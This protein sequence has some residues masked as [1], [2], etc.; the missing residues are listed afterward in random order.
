MAI[1]TLQ[2]DFINFAKGM[3]AVGISWAQVKRDIDFLASILAGTNPGKPAASMGDIPMP[4]HNLAYSAFIERLTIAPKG[5]GA[6]VDIKIAAN[7]H[8]RGAPA[9]V[10]YAYEIET[11]TPAPVVLDFDQSTNE[12]FWRAEGI[13]TPQING[14]FGTNAD[15][16]LATTDFPEPKRDSYLNEVDRIIKWITA[17]TFVRLVIQAL[18]RYPLGELAPWLKFQA[19]VLT[20]YTASH[21][22][23]TASKATITVGGCESSTITI[24]PDPQFPYG[25]TIPKPTLNSDGVNMAVYS[26]RTRLLDFFAKTIEPGIQVADS[27]GGSIKWALGGGIGLKALTIDIRDVLGLGTIWKAVAPAWRSSFLAC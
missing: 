11:V 3:P 5:S 14:Q 17:P 25:H 21:V 8:P 27:G 7:I 19:P 18:T 10:I 26:P 20:D 6:V 16:I 1:S 22:L 2:F 15:A 9:D 13:A 12:A 4:V 23:I 24:E